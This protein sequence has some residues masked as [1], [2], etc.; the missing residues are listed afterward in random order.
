M[1]G[2]PGVLLGF[3]DGDDP[4][5]LSDQPAS[6]R[7]T[8]A[9]QSLVRYFGPRAGHPKRYFDQVWDREVFTGGCPVGVL[10]PGVMSEYGKALR[11]PAG[12]IHWAGTETATV[13]TGYMDGAVQSGQRAA[14]EVLAGL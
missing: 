12:R 5:A 8:Q 11:A 13:W 9:M 4:R 7:A 2:T 3:I 6:V 10:P 1:N 14:A